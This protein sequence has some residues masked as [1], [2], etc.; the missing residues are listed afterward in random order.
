V[1]KLTL[2]ALIIGGFAAQAQAQSNV[3][4]YGI[5]DAGIVAERGGV[6]GNVNKV[7]S[8]VGSASRLGFKG[9]EDLGDG[10]SAVFVIESGVKVDT[11]ESDVAGS[12]ANRQA[13]VGLKSKD[14]GGISLGRQYTMLYNALSQ[15]A[16]PFG[17]GYAGTAKNLF[18][19]GGV[20]TRTSNAVVYNSPVFSGF[21]VDAQ[22]AMGEQAGNNTAGRQFGFGL[23]LS[24]DNKLNARLVYNNKNNDVAAVGATPAVLKP[25][26]KNTLLAV[27]YDFGVA[28]AYF[29]YEKDKGAGSAPLPVANAYGYK[30]APKSSSDSNVILLGVGVPVGAGTFVA[31]YIRKDDKEFNQ[32]ANQWALGYLHSLSKRTTAYATYGKMKNKNGAGYTIGNNTEAGSGDKA[33]NLGVK[34]TF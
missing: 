27:N 33:L 30:V 31:S 8:G 14:A 4:I 15:V 12:I 29:A 20:N 10:L 5:V 17:A 16:D 7:T 11:G 19:T 28:K 18:P 24:L 25:T 26:A 32:D 6:A 9:T 23:N 13:Y 1:K 34:H 22:Y 21:S 3:T 2:A